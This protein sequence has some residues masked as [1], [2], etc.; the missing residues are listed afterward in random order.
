MELPLYQTI[1]HGIDLLQ[2]PAAKEA[3]NRPAGPEFYRQFYVELEKRPVDP[4]WAAGKAAFGP[5]CVRKFFAP[6]ERQHGRKPKILSLGVG[7]GYIEEVWLREGYDVTL[8]ECQEYSMREL[9][10]KYPRARSAVGDASQM[11]FED[12]YDV[13]AIMALEYSL[14]RADLLELLRRASA[15]LAPGGFILFQSAASLSFRQMAAEAVKFVRHKLSPRPRVF[16][17]WW[18]TVGDMCRLGERAGLRVA[19]IYR[20]SGAAEGLVRRTGPGRRLP[21]CLSPLIVILFEPL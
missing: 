3:Q 2:F 6:R 16:W 20:F 11:Q 13:V 10:N 7:K 8:Q 4:A 21:T 17:G 14:R 12:K 19:D 5:V 15:W 1:W 18:R 9:L